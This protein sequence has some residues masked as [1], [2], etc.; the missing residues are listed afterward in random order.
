MVTASV[1]KWYELGV[2]GA[3]LR[4]VCNAIKNS[5]AYKT[6]EEKKEAL[7]LYYL[8]TMPMPSWPSVAG[9]LHYNEEKTALRAVK[10]FLKDTPAGQPSRHSCDIH[11]QLLPMQCLCTH[12]MYI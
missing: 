3:G 9:V 4:V 2:Y 6:E 8:S 11:G 12:T 7:L 5:T 10:N 1:K